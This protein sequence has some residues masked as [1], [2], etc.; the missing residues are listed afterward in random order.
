MIY[1]TTSNLSPAHLVILESWAISAKMADV[2]SKLKHF[3]GIE[4]TI[5]FAHASA[6]MAI[7]FR[8][9]T[10]QWIFICE[11]DISAR[12][13]LRCHWLE[14]FSVYFIALISLCIVL[15]NYS[16]KVNREMIGHR[17]D[18]AP[19]LLDEMEVS[20]QSLL[21]SHDNKET[22]RRRAGMIDAIDLMQFRA[23]R[24]EQAY[25]YWLRYS[26]GDE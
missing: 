3:N 2:G 22:T 11:I 18:A 12:I 20:L 8:E 1:L 26:C 16:H 9:P 5:G 14:R 25:F 19:I 7:A 6:S 13:K 24:D 10:P 17:L 15:I 4:D 21:E 23:G